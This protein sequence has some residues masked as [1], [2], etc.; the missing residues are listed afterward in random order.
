ME[1]VATKSDEGEL[2]LY[3]TGRHTRTQCRFES[4]ATRERFA[5]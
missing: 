4:K 1:R 2:I 3:H 5:S